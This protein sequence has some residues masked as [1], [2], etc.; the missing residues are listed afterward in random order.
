MKKVDE[1]KKNEKCSRPVC[2]F[3][4][5]FLN[6]SFFVIHDHV[7]THVS[8]DVPELCNDA[9]FNCYDI[10][11]F[12]PGPCAGDRLSDALII[13]WNVISSDGHAVLQK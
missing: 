8:A 4:N 7:R 3:L 6:Y 9:S 2:I 13:G 10:F 12:L 11:F 5:L 1:K